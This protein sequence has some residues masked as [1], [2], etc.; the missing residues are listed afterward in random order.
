QRRPAT[1]GDAGVGS[2][3]HHAHGG[4]WP[5]LPHARRH[6]PIG[7][8]AGTVHR[9]GRKG[10]DLTFPMPCSLLEPAQKEDGSSCR[11]CSRPRAGAVSAIG[12][13]SQVVFFQSW[14]ESTTRIAGYLEKLLLEPRRRYERSLFGIQQLL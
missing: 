1:C 7:G 14:E 11:G 3:R 13:F 5:R 4:R 12:S 2:R 9:R 6:H 10:E 8:K